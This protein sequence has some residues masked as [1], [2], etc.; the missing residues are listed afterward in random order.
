M[1]ESPKK[2]YC[3]R[4]C[5]MWIA[6]FCIHLVLQNTRLDFHGLSG[7]GRDYPKLSGGCFKTMEWIRQVFC[8]D[9][10]LPL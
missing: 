2:E 6:R 8:D 9:E 3:V 10:L 7:R 5:E 4:T 1:R